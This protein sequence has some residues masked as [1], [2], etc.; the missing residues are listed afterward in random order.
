MTEPN[1]T[2]DLSDEIL[3]KSS[4]FEEIDKA[5]GKTKSPAVEYLIAKPYSYFNM[6]GYGLNF[7]WYGHSAVIYTMPDGQRKVFNI[8]S[9]KDRELVKFHTPEDY[10]FTRNSN[11]G[12]IFNRDFIG[13]RVEDL[14]EKD[15]IIMDKKFQEIHDNA[16]KGLVKFDIIF[17]PIYNFFKNIF[18]NISERGNC[19]RWSS[20]GLQEARILKR[21]SVWPKAIFI[22]IFENKNSSNVSVVSYKQIEHVKKDYGTSGKNPFELVSPFQTLRNLFYWNLD[23]YS[24]AVVD[25]T[26]PKNFAR[27]TLRHPSLIRRPCMIRNKIVNHPIAVVA[28]G[29]TTVYLLKKYFVPYIRPKSV[30]NNKK[31]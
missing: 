23:A 24:H 30:L 14:P 25:V 13:I 1:S 20:L 8:V 9:G 26:Y 27:V 6:F 4:I 2:G 21:R 5:L 16:V 19:A 28:C 18:P 29:V 3:N 10:L 17:G 11:Q 15:I 31:G 22:D 12:G 7:N